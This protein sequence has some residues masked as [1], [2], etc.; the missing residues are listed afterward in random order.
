MSV[1]GG[2]R[3][4]VR[5]GGFLPWAFAWSLRVEAST[6]GEQSPVRAGGF[7][8]TEVSLWRLV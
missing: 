7:L 1:L 3:P 2:E 4:P 8:P 5:A 6:G